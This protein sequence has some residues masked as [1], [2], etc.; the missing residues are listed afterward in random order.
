MPILDTCLSSLAELGPKGL[1]R[2]QIAISTFL[3]GYA[4]DAV[5][6]TKGLRLLQL[7]FFMQASGRPI[8]EKVQ[9]AIARRL[10]A[11]TPALIRSKD[12]PISLSGG[13][14]APSSQ[15]GDAFGPEIT[16]PGHA[17]AADHVPPAAPDVEPASSHTP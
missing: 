17:P 6:Q 14:S 11:L 8:D 2:G 1:P 4:S 15:I 3:A 7:S 10:K 5:S 9:R 16:G 13:V 12:Q